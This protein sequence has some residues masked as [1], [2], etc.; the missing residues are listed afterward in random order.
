MS[1]SDNFFGSVGEKR[2]IRKMYQ[3]EH[4]HYSLAT[5][6]VSTLR[7]SHKGAML[8]C[9]NLVKFLK[10]QIGLSQK[11]FELAQRNFAWLLPRSRGFFTYILVCL[12]ECRGVQTDQPTYQKKN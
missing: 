8:L 4:R 6:T 5:T 2:H 3:L 9:L 11:L 12:K 1:Q 7:F 10:I